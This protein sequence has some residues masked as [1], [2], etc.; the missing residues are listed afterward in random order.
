M[1][2]QRKDKNDKIKALT[3]QLHQ[4]I[5]TLF[6][7]DRYKDYLRSM[8]KFHNYSF[9][10]SLL[11]WSQR[12]DATAVAGYRTWQT[13]FQRRVNPGAKGIMIIEPAPREKTVRELVQDAPGNPVTGPDGEELTREVRKTYPGFKVGYVFAYENTTGKPLPSLVTTLDKE[14]DNCSILLNTLQK[15]SPV[16]IHFTDFKGGAYGYY[17]LEKREIV[18]KAD[19][20]PAH[21]LKTA[22]H[23]V[24][25]CLLHDRIAG[26]DREANRREMEVSAESVAFVVCSYL[27]LDTGE[28][29]FGYIG[30]W[31][32]G[33]ELAELQ[34]KMEVIRT[35]ANAIIT[36][37]EQASMLQH[38]GPNPPEQQRKHGSGISVR[39][40]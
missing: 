2:Q 17:D 16:P 34:Q 29:S 24:S 9:N 27:G 38:I 23:E 32:A 40:R 1:E 5:K 21:K 37:M 4:G 26:L 10:N 15:I 35:A 12:P 30:G 28:Y 22:V 33:Q 11:I 31:S 6:E 20:P 13:R 36:G 3:E 8:A 7:S 19:L 25:H 14:P 18:V 39:R